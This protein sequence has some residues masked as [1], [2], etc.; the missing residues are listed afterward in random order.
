MRRISITLGFHKVA[1]NFQKSPFFLRPKILKKNIFG[2]I[3]SFTNSLAPAKRM[4]DGGKAQKLIFNFV[5]VL[6]PNLTSLSVFIQ[7][8]KMEDF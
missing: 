8:E 4:K 7:L 5:R 1:K 3:S 2:P 6:A